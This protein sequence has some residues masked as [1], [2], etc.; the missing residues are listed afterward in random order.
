MRYLVELV[1]IGRLCLLI[2]CKLLIRNCAQRAKKA[3][4]PNPLY[5]RCTNFD[6][7]RVQQRYLSYEYAA[8]PLVPNLSFNAGRSELLGLPHPRTRGFRIV[9]MRNLSVEPTRLNGKA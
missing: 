6:S 1:G 5:K 7:D 9:D 4:I 2:L 3:T 8:E